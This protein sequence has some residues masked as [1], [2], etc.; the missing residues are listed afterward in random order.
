[1]NLQRLGDTLKL[2]RE[3]RSMSYRRVAIDAGVSPAYYAAIEKAE[4]I[5]NRETPTRPKPEK[6]RSIAAV[7]G[8]DPSELLELAG[9]SPDA[10]AGADTTSLA[11]TRRLKE[12]AE[13]VR[14]F[15]QRDSVL[16]AQAA[17]RIE[18]FVM[19]IEAM[20]QGTYRCEGV[21]DR[22]MRVRA[23]QSCTAQVFSVNIDDGE[24][25]DSSDIVAYL[26]AIRALVER[27][28][29]AVVS[30]FFVADPDDEW[31]EVAIKRYLAALGPHP[32]NVSIY[33]IPKDRLPGLA[34]S[35]TVFDDRLLREA[36]PGTK[37]VF[38]DDSGRLADYLRQF[39]D[40]IL[41]AERSGI[42]AVASAS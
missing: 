25:W 10:A 21:E 7:F 20:A 13:V 42:E 17:V 28:P 27:V 26:E 36:M 39:N 12:A 6:I 40:L 1:M 3:S 15:D 4:G 33:R 29:D 2:L 31:A 24:F 32:A 19:G 22:E 41:N 23:A 16:R 37:P 35:F 11:L 5:H 30:E 18:D 38:T 9:Y 14:Q 34:L 8:V